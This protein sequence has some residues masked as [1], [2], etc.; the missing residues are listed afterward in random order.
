MSQNKKFKKKST[1]E[2]I[3][4]GLDQ[5]A[6]K[7][8]IFIEKHKQ[9]VLYGISGII[10]LFLAY[11]GYKNYYKEP[12]EVEAKENFSWAYEM[13]KLDSLDLALNGD[14]NNIGLL[15]IIDRYGITKT[16]DLSNYCAGICYIKQGKYVEAIDLL[17][18]FSLNDKI[19]API[20]K[21]AIGDAFMEMEQYEDALKYYK[22]A[23][24]KNNNNTTTPFYL[25]KAGKVCM[26]LEKNKDALNFFERIKKDFP[27]SIEAN[28]IDK[29]IE[30][31]KQSI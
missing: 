7:L 2:E 12:L 11:T 5:G 29:F 13:F 4:T 8:E 25:M 19:L 21:G 16:G 27:S 15:E 10:I 14:G 24:N 20:S 17:N 28:N 23:I 30:R 22:N 18:N 31:M 3:F 1:T 26:I 6:S 9:N